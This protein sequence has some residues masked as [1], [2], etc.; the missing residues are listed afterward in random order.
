MI[1]TITLHCDGRLA[2]GC[3]AATS[4][5]IGD[6][7]SKRLS[8][9][10]ISAGWRLRPVGTPTGDETHAYCPACAERLLTLAAETFGVHEHQDDPHAT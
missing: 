5:A 8:A 6:N 4:A 1:L 3:T 7:A 10:A 9:H 2:Y